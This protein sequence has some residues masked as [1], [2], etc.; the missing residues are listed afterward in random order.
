MISNICVRYD[1]CLKARKKRIPP[2]PL[3][4]SFELLE[5]AKE[6]VLSVP[7]LAIETAR[8]S[9]ETPIKAGEPIIFMHLHLLLTP[10]IR[11]NR[12]VDSSRPC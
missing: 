8:R 10:S 12:N 5:D 7:A 6:D 4:Y 1:E 11:V 3:K 9:N 2:D